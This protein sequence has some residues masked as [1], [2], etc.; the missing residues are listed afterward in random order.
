MEEI[1]QTR[2]LDSSTVVTKSALRPV[3]LWSPGVVG[4][5][6]EVLGRDVRFQ[7]CAG[8]GSVWSLDEWQ[9]AI[10]TDGRREEQAIEA[11]QRRP[12]P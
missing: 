8:S 4:D 11:I 1:D 2:L 6:Y 5:G 3:E 7:T 9:C 10:S 12:E